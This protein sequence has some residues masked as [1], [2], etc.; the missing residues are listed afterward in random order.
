MTEITLNDL[1]TGT[2]GGAGVFDKLMAS[3]KAHLDDQFLEGRIKGAE[4]ATVY[5]GQ[6]QQVLQTSVAFLAQRQKIGLEAEL[7]AKQIELT[8]AQV[9]QAQAQTALLGAQKD[10]EILQ[11]KVLVAQECLLKAQFDATMATAEKT[12]AE[13]DLLK[14]KIV[15]EKAQTLELGVDDNS[16]IGRQKELY[17]KQ[18]AGFDRDAEQKAVKI[19][20]DT[21][22]ARRMTDDGTVADGVNMLSDVTGGRLMSKLLSGIDA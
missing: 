5:L 1:T 18:S 14:Q 6:V 2:L 13:T 21:W 15:T 19:W 8:Q 9:E 10:N 20:T 16:V 22:N 11:G 3:T 17:V 7:L 4:Y 12:A